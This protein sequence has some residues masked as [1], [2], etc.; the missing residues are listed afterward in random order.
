MQNSMN[1]LIVVLERRPLVHRKSNAANRRVLRIRATA[2]DTALIAASDGAVGTIEAD[3]F[4]GLDGS[5]LQT[6][7][8]SL[9]API[10]R[11]RA[12]RLDGWVALAAARAAPGTGRSGRRAPAAGETPGTQADALRSR[13]MRS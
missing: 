13:A 1:E 9:S 5:A 6:F 8:R 11:M 4:A 3:A 12:Q 2:A 7:R 10:D